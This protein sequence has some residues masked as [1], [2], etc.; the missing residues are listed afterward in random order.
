MVVAVPL[1]ESAEPDEVAVAQEACR[2][3]QDACSVDKRI[4]LH[5]GHRIPIHVQMDQTSQRREDGAWNSPD[6]IVAQIPI[7]IKLDLFAFTV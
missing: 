7:E 3:D 6:F 1:D 4:R 2:V 5:F